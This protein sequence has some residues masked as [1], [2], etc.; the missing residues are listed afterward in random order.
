MIKFHCPCGKKLGV[1]GELAGRKVKCPG[2]GSPLRVP[3]QSPESPPPLSMVNP[4]V[5]CPEC[6]KELPA[7]AKFCASCG[8]QIILGPGLS[9]MIETKTDYSVRVVEA[10]P[11]GSAPP[12]PPV[13]RPPTP[14]PRR[15][16]VASRRLGQA[17]KKPRQ[18]VALGCLGF[19]LLAVILVAIAQPREPR[20]SMP[21]DALSKA[22]IAFVGNPTRE[23]IKVKM[24]AAMEVWG[25][26][27]RTEGSYAKAAS[28]LIAVRKGVG[29]G[30]TE[31]DILDTMVDIPQLP[32]A[33]GPCRTIE[34]GEGMFRM[35]VAVAAGMLQKG[36]KPG[37]ELPKNQPDTQVDLEPPK[38]EG[39]GERTG[40]VGS[41]T[42]GGS[43][44]GV[45]SEGFEEPM[46]FRRSPLPDVTKLVLPSPKLIAKFDVNAAF[47]L[48]REHGLDVTQ[49]VSKIRQMWKTAS[50]L[51]DN[52]REIYEKEAGW[53]EYR[54]KSAIEG[55]SERW[56]GPEGGQFRDR[57]TLTSKL[58]E[59]VA[60]LFDRLELDL[61]KYFEVRKHLNEVDAAKGSLVDAFEELGKAVDAWN[62]E[63]QN[64]SRIREYADGLR[65]LRPMREAIDQAIARFAQRLESTA[66]LMTSRGAL[67]A[68]LK[69]I[70]D[71]YARRLLEAQQLLA[72]STDHEGVGVGPGNAV[73]QEGARNALDLANRE[74]EKGH[75]LQQAGQLGEARA[76]Y[77]K[78]QEHFPAHPQAVE[79][80]TAFKR[81]V[82][83][84]YNFDRM[85]FKK[86]EVS[87]EKLIPKFENIVA[88]LSRAD[89]P[90]YEQYRSAV[91]KL[92][93]EGKF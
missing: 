60:D 28:A 45:A 17:A 27:P 37:S 85:R 44:P 52:D 71:T 92:K 59:K 7:R 43:S 42:K 41:S 54:F 40:N 73:Q 65:S 39:G 56:Y 10:E 75:E 61:V 82:A 81:Q 58:D 21:Q 83:N 6:G 34:E 93:T 79:A 26:L 86:G 87:V 8:R 57:Y 12:V 84:D 88:F 16:V 51:S 69:G 14:A 67:D 31:I 38:G 72:T 3:D 30:I 53:L 20:P 19:V 91:E 29:G 63:M 50:R 64:P 25:N 46:R 23:T 2:C 1:K 32:R 4:H 24:D 33:V 35:G 89:G 15:T 48:N 78:A 77:E 66:P 18:S 74:F 5:T 11:V 22:S 49:R 90:I 76:H 62:A 47:S 80:I 55:N 36:Y 68:P 13:L 70:K 9:R